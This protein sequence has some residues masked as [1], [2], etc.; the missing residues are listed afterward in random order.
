M[1]PVWRS[2]GNSDA[3]FTRTPQTE[4]QRLTIYGKLV[5]MERPAGEPSLWAGALIVLAGFVFIAGAVTVV[6]L[7]IVAVSA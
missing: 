5:P 6:K 7:L 2:T 3:V 1:T 4:G